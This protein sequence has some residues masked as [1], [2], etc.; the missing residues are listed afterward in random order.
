M[1]PI[2]QR[3]TYSN[4]IEVETTYFYYNNNVLLATHLSPQQKSELPIIT[5]AFPSSTLKQQSSLFQHTLHIY[6]L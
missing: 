2:K 3:T 1:T 4:T 5:R 6:L